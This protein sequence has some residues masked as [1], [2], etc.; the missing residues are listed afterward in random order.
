MLNELHVW[1]PDR[2]YGGHEHIWR[3]LDEDYFVK[4]I[5]VCDDPNCRAV[6]SED[7]QRRDLVVE[8]SDIL[9]ESALT[10]HTIPRGGEHMNETE[11]ETTESE[12]VEQDDDG[13]TTVER[14][15]TERESTTETSEPAIPASEV[16]KVVEEAK[17]DK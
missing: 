9:G 13:A 4:A 7:W 11:R 8:R 17:G 14:E 2:D 12:R 3:R 16:E 10:F 15:T 5:Q 1:Q 6:R